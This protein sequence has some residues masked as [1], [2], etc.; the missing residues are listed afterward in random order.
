LAEKLNKPPKPPEP[1]RPQVDPTAPIG[2]LKKQI[3][4]AE[5]MLATDA[6]EPAQ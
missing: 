1:E 6:Q 5:Q 2:L 4:K 3:V